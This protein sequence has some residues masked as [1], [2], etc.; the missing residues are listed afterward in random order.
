MEAREEVRGD[1]LYFTR[2]NT[3]WMDNDAY[4]HINNAVYYSYFDTVVNQHAIEYGGFD[5]S[6]ADAIG[7]VLESRCRYHYSAAFPETLDAGLRVGHLGNSSVRY[8]LAMFRQGQAH[9]AVTGHFVHVF[10]NRDSRRPC[11]IPES[12]RS[13]LQQLLVVAATGEQA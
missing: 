1:Y 6:R 8:E 13:R 10:V 9:P 2:V 12:L 11:P 4:G 5:L 7:L 3:R